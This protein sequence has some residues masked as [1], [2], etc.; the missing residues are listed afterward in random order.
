MDLG[1]LQESWNAF[2]ESD[3]LWAILVDPAKKGG[4]W[5]WDEFFRTGE[6]DMEQVLRRVAAQG[7][8]I[9][10]RKAL[11]FGCGVGTRRLSAFTSKNTSGWTSRL[12]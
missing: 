7:V 3:P 9:R 6:A 11:D 4:K 8:E 12:R 2:G 5:D 1:K 10:R